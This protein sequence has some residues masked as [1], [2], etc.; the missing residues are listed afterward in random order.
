MKMRTSSMGH[1][2]PGNLPRVDP[3]DMWK[4]VAVKSN[5]FVKLF[6]LP[7]CNLHSVGQ[8]L[9]LY[10]AHAML[11]YLLPAEHTKAEYSVGI[12]ATTP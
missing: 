3:S 11:C 4:G 2:F 12:S 7:A 10:S 6:A 8:L 5:E 1:N 9:K